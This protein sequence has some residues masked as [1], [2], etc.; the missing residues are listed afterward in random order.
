[1]VGKRQ[2]SDLVLY[3]LPLIDITHCMAFDSA[4]GIVRG[5]RSCRC[6]A[7]EE[8]AEGYGEAQLAGV[9]DHY[10]SVCRALYVV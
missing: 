9:E 8:S 3:T 7:G 10:E 6:N 5:R 1:M 2:T 4:S